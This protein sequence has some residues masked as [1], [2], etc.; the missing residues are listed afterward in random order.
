ML[1]FANL[2]AVISS[3]LQGDSFIL[4]DW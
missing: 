1:P 3:Q 2:S 4:T